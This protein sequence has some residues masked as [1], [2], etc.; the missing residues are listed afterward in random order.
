[1]D[2]SGRRWEVGEKYLVTAD[3]RV[4]SE[5]IFFCGG[6]VA[7]VHFDEIFVCCVSVT[8]RDPVV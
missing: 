2:A 5:V 8:Q 3:A 6:W 1:M 4:A 7:E